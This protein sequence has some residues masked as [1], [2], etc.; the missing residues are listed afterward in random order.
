MPGPPGPSLIHMGKLRLSEV[1]QGGAEA[2]LAD[3]LPLT[4]PQA[5]SPS[6]CRNPHQGPGPQPSSRLLPVLGWPPFP[7]LQMVSTS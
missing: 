3:N 6:E 1:T 7:N 4:Q 5:T 2:K